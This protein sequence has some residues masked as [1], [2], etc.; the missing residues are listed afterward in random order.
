MEI[1]SHLGY[2]YVNPANTLIGNCLLLNGEIALECTMI[3]CFEFKHFTLFLI[4]LKVNKRN[5]CNAHLIEQL[6]TLL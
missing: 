5:S 4:L 3:Q 6:P 1:F 2:I